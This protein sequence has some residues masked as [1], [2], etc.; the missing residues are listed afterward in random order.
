MATKKSKKK[1]A[2]KAKKLTPAQKT[3]L[4]KA[5]RKG[6]NFMGKQLDAE[7]RDQIVQQ[8]EA[9][10]GSKKEGGLV[11]VGITLWAARIDFAIASGDKAQVKQ[12]TTVTEG[13][14]KMR[15]Y[16]DGNCGCGGGGTSGW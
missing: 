12:L 15:R 4:L 5:A 9:F 1:K 6:F 7:H 14:E 10:K 13:P 3:A 11:G 16:M 2:G 8:A